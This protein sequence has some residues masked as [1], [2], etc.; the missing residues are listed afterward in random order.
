M[1]FY[2]YKLD[3][4]TTEEAFS[5]TEPFHHAEG[6]FNIHGSI[7]NHLLYER[8]LKE[9]SR[10][11]LPDR[12]APPPHANGKPCEA[13]QKPPAVEMIAC[14]DDCVWKVWVPVMLCKC[15]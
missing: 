2:C 15:G 11:Y 14:G 3:T 8:S 1:F 12:S 7:Q 6:S 4:V 9:P 13:Q 5:S 10:L